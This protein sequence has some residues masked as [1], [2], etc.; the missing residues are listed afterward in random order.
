[1]GLL[2]RKAERSDVFVI[3]RLVSAASIDDDSLLNR[4]ATDI[5][6]YIDSFL[7]GEM[8]GEIMGCVAIHPYSSELCEVRSH[9][10]DKRYRGS[11]LGTRLIM[12]AVQQAGERYPRVWTDAKKAD[13][14]VKTLGFTEIPRTRMP[15]SILL[16]KLRWVFAQERNRWI[17]SLTGRFTLLELTR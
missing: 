12:A 15:L 3:H 6:E 11:G 5:S 2:I 16:Q 10:I 9:V 7:V 17:P 14:F 1:M 8:D 4:T 13:F